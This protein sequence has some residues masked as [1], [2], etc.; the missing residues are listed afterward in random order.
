[1]WSYW[2]LVLLTALC[3]A[4]AYFGLETV[5]LPRTGLP[6]SPHRKPERGNYKTRRIVMLCACNIHV[7]TC[8]KKCT[9]KLLIYVQVCYCHIIQE[10]GR[11]GEEVSP[12]SRSDRALALTHVT[13]LPL[14][15]ICASEKFA[16]IY[17]TFTCIWH[18]HHV[19]VQVVCVFQM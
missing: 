16:N 13:S 2:K 18:V 4:I 9:K 15:Y 10:G 19:H 17:A 1:M 5:W 3:I 12:R 6:D 14:P 8:P 11:H 7:A